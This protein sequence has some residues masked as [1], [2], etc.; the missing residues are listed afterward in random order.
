[1]STKNSTRRMAAAAHPPVITLFTDFGLADPFVGAM[2]GVILEICPQARIVD[3]SHDAARFDPVRAGFV[4]AT[5]IPYFP[6]G[7]IHVAVVDPGVGGPRRP[8]AARIDGR[9]FVAPD[10][11]LLSCLLAG[12]R[13]V[14]ARHIAN[15]RL[16]REPVSATFHG[17]DVFAPAAAHLACGF[18]LG[19]VGPRVADPVCRP[20]PV[21]ARG[22][23]PALR[24]LV[25]WVDRFG[26]LITNVDVAALRALG[27]SA[28]GELRVALGGG[29]AAPL[30]THY[31]AVPPGRVGAVL[32]SSGHLELFANRASAADLLGAGPGARLRVWRASVR[33]DAHGATGRARR[34]RKAGRGGTGGLMW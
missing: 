15:R 9:L 24:G 1:M 29:R 33:A 17:R 21:P 12:A 5:V 20:L 22:P 6:A 10:N 8:L 31:G 30:V 27:A 2:K 11:G 4:L 18:S 16:L 19:R 34:K 28:R 32:G 25:M 14:E 13:R 7:A 26:N 3:L 23:G